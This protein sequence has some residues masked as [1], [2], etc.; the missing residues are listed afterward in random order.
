ML[1]SSLDTVI[2][3]LADCPIP[4]A[5]K[6]EVVQVLVTHMTNEKIAALNREFPE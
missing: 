3:C 4:E 5:D 6:L 1:D 2:E